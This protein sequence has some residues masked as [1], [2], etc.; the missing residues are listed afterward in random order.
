LPRAVNNEMLVTFLED[1]VEFGATKGIES[2]KGLLEA[3]QNDKL[4]VPLTFGGNTSCT[5]VTTDDQSFFVDMGSGFREAGTSAMQA[6]RKEFHVFMT[7]MHWDHVMGMPFFIP[8]HVPGHKINIYHVHKNA[9]EHI[10]INFNGVN[11]PLTWDQLNGDI[12]FHQLKLYEPN[13]F[14]E[15]TVTPFSLDHPGG[16]FGY[17]FDTKKHSFAIGVDGEFKRLTPK[18]LGKDLAFYQ[19]LDLLLFD[20]QY[21]LAELASRFDWGHCSP[22]IGVDLALRENIKNI[23]F[24]HHDPWSTETKLRRMFETAQRYCAS[25]I[26]GYIE[27]WKD[28]P[29]GPN[30]KMAYDGLTIDLAKGL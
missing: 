20:A 22:H 28:Q 25:Q 30:M 24:T 10:K 2:A 23:V 3:V 11:F 9:P 17:R 8:V 5:E 29:K 19:N 1:I 26:D 16:S 13:K 6:G 21:E 12:E 15:T 7:H 14:G 4:H 27:T 18:E